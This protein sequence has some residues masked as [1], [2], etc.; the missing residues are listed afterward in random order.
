MKSSEDP[1][2]SIRTHPNYPIIRSGMPCSAPGRGVGGAP[3]SGLLL[4]QLGYAWGSHVPI[5]PTALLRLCSRS[6]HG[7]LH[8]QGAQK[9]DGEGTEEKKKITK[10]VVLLPCAPGCQPGIVVPPKP[11][12]HGRN[13]KPSSASLARLPWWGASVC[14]CL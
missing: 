8:S 2:M 3:V 9:E 10:L 4:G 5:S 13:P 6:G 14:G 7:H 11:L 1:G 12:A